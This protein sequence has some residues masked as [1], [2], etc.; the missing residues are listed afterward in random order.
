MKFIQDECKVLPLHSSHYTS[1]GQGIPVT[2]AIQGVLA[3]ESALLEAVIDVAPESANAISDFFNGYIGSDQDR[4]VP[5]SSALTQP[6][7]QQ[8]V[9]RATFQQATRRGACPGVRKAWAAQLMKNCQ[10]ADVYYVK[11]GILGNTLLL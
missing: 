3:A 6:P 11:L 1:I 10:T 8:C 2:E 4:Q 9:N 7:W 5:Q